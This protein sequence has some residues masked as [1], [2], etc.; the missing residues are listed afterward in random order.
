MSTMPTYPD[1]P[2]RPARSSRPR[3]PAQWGRGGGPRGLRAG[4]RPLSASW[5]RIGDARHDG[6]ISWRRRNSFHVKRGGGSS[7]S[8]LFKIYGSLARGRGSHPFLVAVWKGGPP[9]PP[10]RL[11]L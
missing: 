10:A 11:L 8:S 7:A 6:R 2:T 9:A 1:F 3:V 4:A 5:R